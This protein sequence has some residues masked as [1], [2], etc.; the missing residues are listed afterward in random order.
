MA[1]AATGEPRVIGDRKPGFT[2]TERQ[3]VRVVA[4]NS[5]G[6][7][8]LIH[9]QREDYYKLPGGGIE[10]GE[11]HVTAVQREMLE[12]TGVVIKVRGCGI[13]AS[14]EEYRLHIHQF[15]HCYLADV[16]R[17]TGV[18]SLTEGELEDQFTHMWVSVEEAKRLLVTAQPASVFGRSVR[19]RDIYLLEQTTK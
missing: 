2:Y 19:E 8:A 9:A 6:Q 13:V 5:L 11:D 10:P 14:T 17:D 7:I 4:F 16:V 15:S 1:F 18:V 3:A 12:E